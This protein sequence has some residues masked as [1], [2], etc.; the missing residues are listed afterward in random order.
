MGDEWRDLG[1]ILEL[2]ILEVGDDEVG[3]KGK[4][5]GVEHEGGG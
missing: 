2:Q 3:V 5:S 4:L 1:C